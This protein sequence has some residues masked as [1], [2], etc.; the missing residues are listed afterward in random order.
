MAATIDILGVIDNGTPRAVTVPK[1]LAHEI[2]LPWKTDLAIRLF[3][4]HPNGEP[5]DL[6]SDGAATFTLAVRSRSDSLQNL[7]TATGTRVDTLGRGHVSMSIPATGMGQVLPQ[8]YVYDV[9]VV[10]GGDTFLAVPLS[11]FLV[12]ATNAPA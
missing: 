8:R 2:R 1:N 10:F 9:R 11:P 7:I 3:L 4:V 12:Q 5:V 6:A